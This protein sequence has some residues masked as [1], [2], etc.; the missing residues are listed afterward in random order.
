M[1]K[2][3]HQK[4]IKGISAIEILIVVAFITIGLTSLLGVISHSLKIS[5]SI[6]ETTQ[7]NIIAQETMEAVRNF[8]DGTKWDLDGLGKL[9]AS[10]DYYPQATG[11]PLKWQLVLGT[12]TIDGFTRKVVFENISRDPVNNNIED[13][14]NLANDDSNTRKVIVT[15]S[16]KDKEVKLGSYLT[17]WQ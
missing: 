9:V 13:T 1:I 11:S 3:N 14:Y 6:K 2:K 5:T 17:N 12:E 7:A 8:R 16:W 10:A 4:L 15:V